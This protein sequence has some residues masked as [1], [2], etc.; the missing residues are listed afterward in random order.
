MIGEVLGNYRVLEKLGQGGMA[1]VFRAEHVLLGSQ[2]AIKVLLREVSRQ[3]TLVERLCNEARIT[4]NIH[5]RGIV[6]TFDF[7]R[8]PNR[9]PYLVMEY[10]DG[11]SLRDRLRKQTRLPLSIALAYTRQLASALGAAHAV[12]IVHRDLTP[13]N[14]FLVDDPELADIERV[15]ILDFGIAKHCA[16]AAHEAQFAPRGRAGSVFPANLPTRSI[17][18]EGVMLGTPH[19]MSP[20]Q[21]RASRNIDR[22]S[23]LYSLGCVMYRMLL[24]RPPFAGRSKPDVYR[25]HIND[26]P[27]DP[28]QVDP[29]IP[30]DVGAIILRLLAKNPAER[31]ND[32]A[33]LSQ[34]LDRAAYRLQHG[35]P[36]LRSAAGGRVAAAGAG[37]RRRSKPET[38]LTWSRLSRK[39][40]LPEPGAPWWRSVTAIVGGALCLLVLLGFFAS[41]AGQPASAASLD[42]AAVSAR[43]P[44]LLSEPTPPVGE[45]IAAPAE[46]EPVE[47]AITSEPPGADVYQMPESVRIGTTPFVVK[48]PRKVPRDPDATDGDLVLFLEKPGFRTAELVIDS[49]E[50]AAEAAS[51][52]ESR[53]D[54]LVILIPR[55]EAERAAEPGSEPVTDN[56]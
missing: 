7:G 29:A 15:R 40:V 54:E 12:G 35:G 49:G 28:S 10:L 42:P 11:D 22:R 17:T 20:E 16:G 13:A 41:R 32:A 50:L 1:E 47:L 24:G 44:A 25:A 45:A 33:E 53:S 18:L 43:A 19:Y 38:D 26:V 9:R 3:K 56:R 5:H 27:C 31:F 21:C 6:R 8:C 51:G 48:V 34:A 39:D 55:A 30:R 4:A 2:V 23:D 36:A 37:T 52:P 14:I 46:L